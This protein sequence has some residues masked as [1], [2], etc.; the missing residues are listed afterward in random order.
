[1]RFGEGGSLNSRGV[2]VDSSTLL[3]MDVFVLVAVSHMSDGY[4]C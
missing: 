1:M 2:H 3:L 4:V